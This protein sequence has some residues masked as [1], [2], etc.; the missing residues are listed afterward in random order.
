[1]E[2]RITNP[3]VRFLLGKLFDAIDAVLTYPDLLLK[4]LG[5]R[6]FFVKIINEETRM[7]EEGTVVS[8]SAFRRA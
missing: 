4:K 8:I 1:M 7:I 3:I 5:R 6:G 2:F